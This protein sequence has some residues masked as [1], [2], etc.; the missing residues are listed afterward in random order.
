MVNQMEPTPGERAL[1]FLRE[2]LAEQQGPL[3][4]Q[5]TMA[6]F[7]NDVAVLVHEA[8]EWERREHFWDEHRHQ[9]TDLG[10]PRAPATP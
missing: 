2:T 8:D 4:H 7:W 6:K 1:A 3:T 9:T 5:R 10:T